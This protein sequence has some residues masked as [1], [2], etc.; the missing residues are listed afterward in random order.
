MKALASFSLSAVLC[1]LAAYFF[2]RW[3]AP[4]V[5]PRAFTNLIGVVAIAGG[6]LGG[7]LTKGRIGKKGDSP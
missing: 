2:I 3:F 5:D 4:E 6:A 1:G 7:F